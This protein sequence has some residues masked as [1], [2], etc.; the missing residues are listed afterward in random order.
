[1]RLIALHGKAGAG[2]DTFADR[3]VERHGFVKRGFADPIYEEVSAA[4]NVPV[5]WLRDRTRKETPQV[6]LMLGAC[7]DKAFTEMVGGS[8]YAPCSPRA[9]LQQWGGDYRRSQDEDYWLKQMAVYATA[10]LQAECAGVVI[11]DMRYLNEARW[12]SQMRGH[13]I[14]IMRPNTAPETGHASEIPLPDYMIDRTVHNAGSIA[15]LHSVADSV[16]RGAERIG[17]AA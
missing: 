5:S 12:V 3:L 4:Y 17:S 16:I 9:V 13:I 2:K 1:M 6:Q 15:Y 8:Y 7:T 14:K 10:A 11:V